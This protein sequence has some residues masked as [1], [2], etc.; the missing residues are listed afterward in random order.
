MSYGFHV[1]CCSELYL[2]MNFKKKSILKCLLFCCSFLKTSLTQTNTTSRLALLR[3]RMRDVQLSAYV[4]PMD[5]AHQVNYSLLPWCLLFSL[6]FWHNSFFKKCILIF[7]ISWL[8]AL[9]RFLL[10]SVM[11]DIYAQQLLCKSHAVN[12]TNTNTLSLWP[13]FCCE[14]WTICVVM[15]IHKQMQCPPHVCSVWCQAFY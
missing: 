2:T 8:Y 5:D 10:W 4:I 9:Q 12:G 11:W 15:Q 6:W 3:Q 7:V 1:F 13:S 14:V